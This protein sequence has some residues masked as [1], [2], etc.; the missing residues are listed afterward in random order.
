MVS[1]F[2]YRRVVVFKTTLMW[3]SLEFL[4]EIGKRCRGN[5]HIRVRTAIIDEQRAIFNHC[6]T[7]IGDTGS[8]ACFFIPRLRS[9]DGS[10][11][12]IQHV[13]RIV[14]IQY[15]G[16]DLVST[17]VVLMRHCVIDQE[18]SVRR[19]NRWCSD[20]Y[21]TGIPMRGAYLDALSWLEPAFGVL[22]IFLKIE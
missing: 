8:E 11:G 7:R 13:R 6:A 18:P 4:N 20:Q 22:A 12:T 1:R 15:H 16:P 5:V 10:L 17:T 3:I 19:F 21:F 2:S 14:L 9:E